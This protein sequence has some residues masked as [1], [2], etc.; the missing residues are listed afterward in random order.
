MVAPLE[1]SGQRY[2]R[3]VAIRRVENR[4]RRTVWLFS[5]DC[6]SMKEIQLENV[7]AGISSCG[8]LR[9]EKTRERSITHGHKVD[10]KE[11]P[12]LKSYNHAKSRCY[13]PNDPKYPQYGG[14]GIRMCDAWRD[15][16]LT[17]LSDMGEKPL[18]KT[19]DRVDVNGHY[20]PRNCRWATTYQQARTRTDNVLVEHEGMKLVLK[21]FAALMGVS[22]KPLHARIR[23]KGQTPHE[24]VAA[25]KA[26]QAS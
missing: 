13:N 19:L 6:G 5:C 23:Y 17:F 11:S 20:E 26:R 7:R 25:M 2:G 22:Y 18:G 24:A 9:I 10:R 15:D 12:T 1:I 3:L 4:G 14:R 8:C 16:F 21:D